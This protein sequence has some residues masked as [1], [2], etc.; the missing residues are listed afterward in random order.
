MQPRLFCMEAQM[1]TLL[2]FTKFHLVS[3]ILSPVFT[4]FHLF[5]YKIRNICY[6]E[7]RNEIRNEK[8]EIR[9]RKTKLETE[10]RKKKREK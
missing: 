8:N 4:N 5:S 6:F 3:E 9:N 1:A 2:N 10:K 7:Q